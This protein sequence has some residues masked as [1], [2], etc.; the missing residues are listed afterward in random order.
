VIVSAK[1]RIPGI[2][3]AGTDSE[4]VGTISA[5]GEFVQGTAVVTAFGTYIANIEGTILPSTPGNLQVMMSH[6]VGTA[7]G[8]SCIRQ[9]S[10]G[11]L[12]VIP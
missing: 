5:S 7:N 12:L 10:A 1:V 9:Q 2:T 3:A 4:I 11:V 6:E 8:G